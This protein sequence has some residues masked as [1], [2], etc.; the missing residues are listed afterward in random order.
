VTRAAEHFNGDPHTIVNEA[1]ASVSS[2]GRIPDPIRA[3][4]D[5]YLEQVR[6]S[7][8]RLQRL[9][10]LS[11]EVYGHGGWKDRLADAEDQLA[12]ARAWIRGIAPHIAA[13][14]KAVESEDKA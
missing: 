12:T 6:L 7:D 13:V 8:L 9:S 11:N 5:A 10:Q 3:L 1:C 14:V 2:G 4:A